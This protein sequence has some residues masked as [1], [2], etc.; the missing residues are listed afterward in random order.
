MS[1][2]STYAV[3]K[4]AKPKAPPAERFWKRYSPHHELPLSGVGS[5]IIHG[6]MVLVPLF[7][8]FLAARFGFKDKPPESLV[9]G[10]A[11]PEGGGGLPEGSDA[12]TKGGTRTT[13]VQESSP[14]TKVAPPPDKQEEL[15][16]PTAAEQKLIDKSMQ[17]GNIPI[18]ENVSVAIGDLSNI[19]QQ[20]RQRIDGLLAPR[21]RGGKGAGGGEGEGQGTEK[22]SGS[23][24]GA[25]EQRKKRQ[26]RWTMVFN[27]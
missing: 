6:L 9:V 21:G 27:T 23:G 19:G 3:E 2:N 13:E 4:P 24:G 12:G 18:P 16:A 1:D 10:I 15:K 22:G 25:L 7:A 14:P 5:V 11:G 26:L 8:L 17:E 20:A